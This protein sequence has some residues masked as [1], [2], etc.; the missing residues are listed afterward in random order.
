MSIYS[1]VRRAVGSAIAAGAMLH[2][3]CTPA[4]VPVFPVTGTVM[5]DNGKPVSTGV[6]E[7]EPVNGGPSARG[8]IGRDGR[9]ELS[10]GDRPGAVAGVHR[11]AVVQTFVLDGVTND[12][13]EDHSRHATRVVAPR[14]ARFATSGLEQRVEPAT[15]DFR[16]V[17]ESAR[18]K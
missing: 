4:D 11:V 12:D 8:K 3:G 10:T 1:R 13:R 17:V 15:N 9:F 6:I 7:F 18:V 2:P 14:Y 5:F 16:V